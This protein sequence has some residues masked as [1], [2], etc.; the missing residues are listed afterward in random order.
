MTGTAVGCPRTAAAE[1]EAATAAL[2]HRLPAADTGAAATASARRRRTAVEAAPGTALRR[3]V[4]ETGRPRGVSRTEA[5]TAGGRPARWAGGRARRAAAGRRCRRRRDAGRRRRRPRQAR[6]GRARAAAYHGRPA[7]AA[8]A[9]TA[10]APP[11]RDPRLAPTRALARLR[12]HARQLAA[13][14]GARPEPPRSCEPSW[15]R[16]L[17]GP[18]LSCSEAFNSA[19]CCEHAALAVRAM[20]VRGRAQR[21]RLHRRWRA[22]AASCPLLSMSMCACN[23]LLWLAP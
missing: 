12:G 5:G 11:A 18:G 7:A 3:G 20:C 17:P 21:S 1:A 19:A 16:D 2:G 13:N 14:R 23:H 6:A 10:R 15:S 8:V 9:R 4:S 22:S